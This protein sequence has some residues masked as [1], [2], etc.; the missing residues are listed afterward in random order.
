MRRKRND[1]FKVLSNT[2][3]GLGG[4]GVVTAVGAGIASKAPAGSPNISGGFS[5]IAGFA[6]VVVTGVAGHAVL[7]TIKQ[8]K[9]KKKFGKY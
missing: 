9:G 3:I 1:P 7:N 6:P 5:T 4:L 2:A 8:K